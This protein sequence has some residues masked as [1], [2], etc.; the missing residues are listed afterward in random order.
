MNCSPLILVQELVCSVLVKWQPH[1]YSKTVRYVVVKGQRGPHLVSGKLFPLLPCGEACSTLS[2]NRLR[3]TC[4]CRLQLC[5]NVEITWTLFLE[6]FRE[7]CGGRN[8]H[9]YCMKAVVHYS[10][11]RYSWQKSGG[12]KSWWWQKGISPDIVARRG[13]IDRKRGEKRC[14]LAKNMH[15]CTFFNNLIHFSLIK[16]R[17]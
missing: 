1:A 14:G 2:K 8:L 16:P 7:K 13:N 11:Y 10:N 3:Q 5:D 4:V 9:T 12:S 15:I 17:G 6:I